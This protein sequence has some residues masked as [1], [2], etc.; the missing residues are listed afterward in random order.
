MKNSFQPFL[1]GR[2]SGDELPQLLFA[3]E[4]LYRSFTSE[5]QLYWSPLG[6]RFYSFSSLNTSSHSLFACKALLR[7]LPVALWGFPCQLQ[8]S[9]LLLPWGSLSVD[10]FVITGLREA[11]FMLSVWGI[12]ELRE[13]G[14]PNLFPDLGC[15]QLYFLK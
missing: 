7:N 6:W 1:H 13:H 15:S 12:Y 5:G 2:C 10:S 14:C 11:L 3:W 8:T 9:F 4:C